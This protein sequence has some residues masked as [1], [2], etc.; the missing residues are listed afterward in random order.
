[1]QSYSV[2]H[3][4]LVLRHPAASMRA[5]LL[6][7]RCIP[8]RLVRQ[9]R[10]ALVHSLMLPRSRARELKGLGRLEVRRRADLQML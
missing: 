10:T 6:P 8:M 3:L 7:N 5:L 1:M 9:Y 4:G 2:S